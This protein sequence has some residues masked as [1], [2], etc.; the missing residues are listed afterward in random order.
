MRISI[1][2]FRGRQNFRGVAQYSVEIFGIFFVIGETRAQAR[3]AARQTGDIA[4]RV[5]CPD[6]AQ[7][8]KFALRV[9]DEKNKWLDIRA[10]K[11]PAQDAGDPSVEIGD[12]NFGSNHKTLHDLT[13]EG[14]NFVVRIK[15]ATHL[16]ILEEIAVSEEEKAVGIQRHA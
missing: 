12:R 4:P 3:Q 5:P 7:L 15:Q 16:E 8:G 1:G 13:E 6:A 14:V 11:S 9:V 10:G 2:Q